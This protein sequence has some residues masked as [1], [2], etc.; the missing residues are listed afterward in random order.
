MLSN[1]VILEKQPVFFD[2]LCAV[3]QHVVEERVGFVVVIHGDAVDE[4]VVVVHLFGC[5][6]IIIAKTQ[7]DFRGEG[8]YAVS[9]DQRLVGS[10]HHE[11][12]GI[13]VDKADGNNAVYKPFV[14]KGL[15][16][17]ALNDMDQ[18]QSLCVSF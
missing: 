17:L 2:G 9:I 4:V 7:I 14:W 18:S 10:I 6:F 11:K 5:G 13:I 16:T 15:F 3:H 8:L 1:G 12:S